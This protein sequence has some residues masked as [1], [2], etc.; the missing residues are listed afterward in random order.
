M[1]DQK[2]C[3]KCGVLKPL[4]DFYAHPQMADGHVNKCKDCNKAD[5]RANY[6]RRLDYYRGYDRVRQRTPE[7][8]AMQQAAGARHRARYPQKDRAR[9]KLR[10]AVRAGKIER[11]PCADCGDMFAEAHHPDYSKPLDVVWLCRICHQK[12]EARRIL[13]RIDGAGS[14]TGL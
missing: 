9:Q 2:R 5:V 4:S 12:R 3:F 10:R 7:R 13:G 14:T 11:G 6:R 1:D 8:R